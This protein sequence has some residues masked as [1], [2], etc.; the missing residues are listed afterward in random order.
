MLNFIRPYNWACASSW[1]RFG[2]F[3]MCFTSSY[4]LIATFHTNLIFSKITSP[5]G[6]AYSLPQNCSQVCSPH[7]L[8]FSTDF[9]QLWQVL[10][11][12]VHRYFDQ[13]PPPSLKRKATDGGMPPPAKKRVSS[14]HPF[15]FI[16]SATPGAGHLRWWVLRPH[17]HFIFEAQS[18]RWRRTPSRKK[19]SK[20]IPSLH[21]HCLSYTRCWTLA[22]ISTTTSFPLHLW[23][24][25]LLMKAYPVPH[26]RE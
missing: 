26:K 17:S 16:V 14:F 3:K 20:F 19:K 7:S 13:I 22:L 9:C 2:W 11:T 18:Y 4:P 23:S 25:K 6:N 10:D 8:Y 5:M 21:L 12:C 15:V 24:A 1:R